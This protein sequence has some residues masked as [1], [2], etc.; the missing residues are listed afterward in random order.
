MENKIKIIKCRGK[1]EDCFENLNLGFEGD[2]K[3]SE[4]ELNLLVDFFM[5]YVPCE[6]R[7]ARALATK[8]SIQNGCYVGSCCLALVKARY[9][10]SKK[11]SDIYPQMRGLD[12]FCYLL[13]THA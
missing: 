1:W 4:K 2:E 6:K 9:Q 12:H 8:I 7:S 3:L 13:A 11:R 5:E 10:F